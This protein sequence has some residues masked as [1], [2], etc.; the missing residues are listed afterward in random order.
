MLRRG[1]LRRQAKFQ[2][3]IVG[4]GPGGCYVAHH[5]LKSRTDIHIDV[6]DQL[7][8]PYG[9]SRY[10]VAADH[11]EVKNVEK[12][13]TK[14]FEERPKDVTFLGNT[15][16]GR[17]GIPLSLLQ[18]NYGAVVLA[19]GAESD[20]ALGIP[21]EKLG[22][23]IAAKRLVEYCNTYPSP[24]GNPRDPPMDFKATRR[25][26]IIGNGNVAMDCARVLGA[27]YKHFCKTDMNCF[28]IRE[29]MESA[30]EEVV[31]V[32]RRNVEHSAFT[33]K[34][35]RELATL[36]NNLKVIVEPFD[37]AG[38]TSR[39]AAVRGKQRML[40][41]MHKYAPTAH[42]DGSGPVDPQAESDARIPV[43]PLHSEQEL[44]TAFSVFHAS[45]RPPGSMQDPNGVRRRVYF[46]YNL[47]PTEI[48]PMQ[49]NPL[50]AGG[51]RFARAGSDQSVVIPCDAVLTSIGY[52]TQPVDGAPF[53]A[54]AAIIPNAAGRVVGSPRLYVAGWAKTG[55]RG[56]ILS[57][58]QAANETA[59][60]ISND[61]DHARAES[62]GEPASTDPNGPLGSTNS[63]K[64]GIIDMMVQTRMVPVSFKQVKHIWHAEKLRGVD[65]GKVAEKN[66]STASMIDIAVGDRKV[67]KRAT[68]RFLGNASARPAGLEMLED[69]LDPETEL[70]DVSDPGRLGPSTNVPF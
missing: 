29:L 45:R 43:H 32:G 48:V 16:V 19:H 11:P 58:M 27:G 23:V 24:F 57:T 53:D 37:L 56:V 15:K 8:V 22:G 50:K 34:E 26:V 47:V 61:F 7:P 17:G 63:G 25:V 70:I 41:L 2:V 35:F 62:S 67:A 39:S 4:S 6:Y 64:Y 21:G 65:L 44:R 36:S 33:T 3:A 66:P 38:A 1:T 51:V 14:M 54:D 13:F 28:A 40:E 68:D 46:A 31:V 9:L 10:G 42:D 30:V 12:T 59:A 5:L 55:P 52:K 69:W 20:R 49:T 60:A 18:E